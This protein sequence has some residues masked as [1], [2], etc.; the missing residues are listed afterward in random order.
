MK[1][2]QHV[3][4]PLLLA[5][6][7]VIVAAVAGAV[8]ASGSGAQKRIH[9]AYFA[10]QANTYAQATYQGLVEAGKKLNADIT[11][12]D[13][14]FDAQKE[15]SQIQDAITL[16]KFQAFVIIALDPVSLIPAVKAAIKAGIK[17]VNT[18]LVLGPRF[19][20][21]QPQ[22]AG[23]SGTVVDL[24][25]YRAQSEVN[26]LL[27]LACKD[28][29]PCKVGWIAGFATIDFERSIKYQLGAVQKIHPN[30]KVVAYQDGGGY[31]ADPAFKIAQN[32]L[33]AHPDINL[34]ATSGDQMT[35]GAEIAV[36]GAGSTGKIRIISGGLS[37]PGQKAVTD[38]RW[39]GGTIAVPKTEGV[40]GG[41]IAIYAAR[42]LKRTPYGTIPVGVS[43]SKLSGFPQVMTKRNISKY[44]CEY[45]G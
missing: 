1:R 32:M 23:Q 37:C 29:N 7:V 19:G 24:P 13:T 15:Y 38:G 3:R 42:G 35:L 30:I 17:V 8:V 34:L 6:A 18:D 10:P 33:Q 45:S 12:F 39:F 28:L 16:K 26:Q 11:R 43:A 20:Y 27:V 41:T 25:G 2:L 4:K 9:I 36:K 40:I 14:G 21:Q 31:L 44:K 5:V 22:V